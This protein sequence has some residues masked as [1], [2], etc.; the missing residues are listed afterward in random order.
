MWVGQPPRYVARRDAT[1]G[2]VERSIDY[3]FE[4][5]REVPYANAS[6]RSLRP[7]V[8]ERDK[9]ALPGLSRTYHWGPGAPFLAEVL[10]ADADLILNHPTIGSR[11]VDVTDHK[12]PL[13]SR[14]IKGHY[15]AG[16][17]RGLEDPLHQPSVDIINKR[18]GIGPKIIL[19]PGVTIDDD[20]DEG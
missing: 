17:V 14:T 1:T 4:R 18:L 15:R 16:L 7:P 9:A 2:K 8:N 3:G 12:G 10:P 11:F 5:N 6:V 20:D 19:P 13:G